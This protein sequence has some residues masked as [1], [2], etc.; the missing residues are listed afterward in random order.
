MIFLQG[1][2]TFKKVRAIQLRSMKQKLSSSENHPSSTQNPSILLFC[3]I[4]FTM[5]K[6]FD[7]L[8]SLNPQLQE[9]AKREL[10]ECFGSSE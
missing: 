7:D 5:E 2:S 3:Q 9:N 1:W 6:L 8:E 4:L 10:A